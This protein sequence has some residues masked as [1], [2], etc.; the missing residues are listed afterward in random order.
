MNIMKLNHIIA[1]AALAFTSCAASATVLESRLHVD[2]SFVAY[3]STSD[4][5]LGTAFSSGNR[6]D[7]ASLGQ[8]TLAAGQDYFL[9]IV[10]NN[11]G[12][13]AGVL[14][15]FELTDSTH[16]FVNGAQRLLTNTDD[17]FGNNTGFDG[18]YVELGDYGFNGSE[19]WYYRD[20]T[21]TDAKWIWAGQNEW[22]DVA[23]FSTQILAE[24]GQTDAPSDLPSDVPSEVPEPASI[25]LLGLGLTSLLAA[26]RRSKN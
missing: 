13:M 16:R 4:T 12:A 19:P 3:L 10:A 6:W 1:A 11:T 26:R 21:S 24:G 15:E 25:A 22:T 9:H 5:E 23:Y 17:W 14:G 8:A 7:L 2:D 20:D 18:N